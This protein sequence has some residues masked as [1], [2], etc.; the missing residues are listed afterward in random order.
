[1]MTNNLQIDRAQVT[2][3][4]RENMRRNLE[5]RLDAARAKQD[6]N[7]IRLLEEESSYIR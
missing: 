1:M 4:H 7:L 5:R 3:A 2:A 6:Q